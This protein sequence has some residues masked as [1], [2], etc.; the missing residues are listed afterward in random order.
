LALVNIFISGGFAHNDQ[1]SERQDDRWGRDAGGTPNTNK[2]IALKAKLFLQIAA[3][4]GMILANEERR[5]GYDDP[6]SLSFGSA[7]WPSYSLFH[8]VK[9]LRQ[10]PM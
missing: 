6:A 9:F 5:G 4:S 3:H 7:P 8:R 10:S 1:I 2:K